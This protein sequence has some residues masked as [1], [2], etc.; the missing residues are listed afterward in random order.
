MQIKSVHKETRLSLVV[1]NLTRITQRSPATNEDNYRH[2]NAIIVTSPGGPD[3]L[4]LAKVPQPEPTA[5][6]LL[7]KVKAMALNRADLLQREG[8]YPPPPGASDILGLE[9]AG[10]VVAAENRNSPWKTGD[11][12]FGLLPGGGY[13]EYVTLRE[14]MALPV[15]AD[16]SFEMAAAIPEA[17]LT[18][19]QALVWLGG[20]Q[21][22]HTVLVH[23]GASGVGTAAIQVARQLGARVIITASA[24]KH[25][26]CLKLGADHAIDYKKGPF[27]G[28][29]LKI[30]GS[31]GVNLIIDFIGGPYFNQNIEILQQDG[32]LVSLATLGGGKVTD[33]DMRRI[34]KKRLRIEGST[35]RTRNQA[36]QIKLTRDFSNFSMPLFETRALSPVI[37]KIFSW[38]DVVEAHRYMEANKNTGKIVLRAN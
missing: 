21:K 8:K 37:D 36:Y 6:E 18:A 33:M 1:V 12:V 5:G 27:A 13:A 31:G 32:R 35:L 30:T 38:H 26:T 16:M 24:P 10:V 20:L 3:V 17:F 9:M 25:A 19:Y 2:M 22:G 29:V 28:E 34:L 15:P 11:R 7:V 4:K 14:E 23:A